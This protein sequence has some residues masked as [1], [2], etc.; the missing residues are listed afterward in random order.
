LILDLADETFEVVSANE[1][2]Q[3]PN[4]EWR[5]FTKI[6]KQGKKVSLRN[7]MQSPVASSE[8]QSESLDIPSDALAHDIQ[9]QFWKDP[10]LLSFYEYLSGSGAFNIP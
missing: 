2:H 10:S 7:V 5:D 8:L 6:F 3:I 1:S 4:P 9:K